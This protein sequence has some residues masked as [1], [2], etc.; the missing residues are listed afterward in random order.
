M[1]I[2]ATPTP[3]QLEKWASVAEKNAAIEPRGTFTRLFR[4]CEDNS[5]R[6]PPHSILS[7]SSLH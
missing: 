2:R 7:E 3:E 6:R 5:R 4:C 1:T